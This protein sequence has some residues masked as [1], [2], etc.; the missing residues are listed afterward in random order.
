MVG[1]G[2]LRVIRKTFGK[3]WLFACLL[4][5]A[6]SQWTPV[7]CADPENPDN[8]QLQSMSVFKRNSTGRGAELFSR[9]CAAC[10]ENAVD[11]APP[12]TIL[13]M[14]SPSSIVRALTDGAMRSQGSTLSATDKTLVAEY[15]T[16]RKLDP[17]AGKSIAGPAKCKGSF[18]NFDTLE[19][20]V[21]SGWGITPHNTREIPENLAGLEPANLQR[22]R[23]KWVVGLPDALRNRSEPALA[24]GALYVG[25]QNGTLYALDRAT[26]CERWAFRTAAEARSGVVVSHWN[27]G[28]TAARPLVFLG[29]LIGNVYAVEA[30]SGKLV[31]KDHPDVHPSA[32]ITG[33]PTLYQGRLYVAVSS[34]EEAMISPR[35]ECCSFRGSIVAYDAASGERLWQTFMMEPASPQGASAGGVRMLGPSGASIWNSPTID[36]KRHRLY[37]GTGDNYSKPSTSTSDSIVA[38]D[39]EDGKIAWTHQATQGD[40]WNVTC[41]LTGHTSCP[42]DSGPDYD[43]GAA[44]ILATASNGR[45]Y[46][47]A[48]QKSGTVVAV[49]PDSGALIWKSKVG[50]GGL[51]GG[52]LFGMALSGDTL[53]VPMND[54]DDGRKYDEP[55]RPGLYALDLRTGEFRWQAPHTVD[56]CQGRAACSQGIGGAITVAGSLVLAGSNDGW[57]SIY[58]AH[59]GK[60]L[61]EFDTARELSTHGKS[62]AHG[63]SIAG[64]AGPLAYRGTVIVS[65]GYGVTGRMPGNALALF[66]V[67]S[68]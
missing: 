24:G 55:A 68:K 46:L 45:D 1:T 67:E 35:Y 10:H 51:F 48:G 30:K 12:Q 37:V 59:D 29:D 22:L 32:T 7:A 34:S 2:T 61:W 28:D 49:D 65:S 5:S 47:V 15:L 40:I 8:A 6:V 64:A 31:W 13:A 42:D 60:L 21:F 11:R 36:E 53:F 38:L 44:T 23:L 39:L 14:M 52:I 54:V 4:S 18:A 3:S 33:A 50:R 17:H 57:M 20:P 43:I 26:G 62:A 41:V 16:N 19:P 58:N 9:I 27:P 56:R 25:S 66:E 63:G